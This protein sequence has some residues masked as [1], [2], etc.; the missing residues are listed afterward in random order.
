MIVQV[1]GALLRRLFAAAALMLAAAHAQAQN[2]EAG[3]DVWLNKC[4]SCHAPED[5]E[6]RSAGQINTA[7]ASVG[8]MNGISLSGT[9]M[10]NLVSY[11]SSAHIHHPRVT[12]LP[13]APGPIN[14]PSVSSGLTRTQNVTVT[15]TGLGDPLNI[16]VGV[17]DNTN[18]SVN[19]NGCGT[20]AQNASCNI[21]VTFRP[22]SVGVFNGRTLTINHNT[23][24]T[25]SAIT[26]NGTGLVEFSASPLTLTYTSPT[27]LQQT[28]IT[29]NKGDALRICRAD[30]A[31]FNFPEDFALDAPNTLGVDGCFTTTATGLVPRSIPLNVR[32]TPGATGPRNGAL[33]IRRFVGGVGVGNTSTVQL[34]GNP[35]PV[36]AVN[37]SSLFD[38]PADPG[39]EVDNGNF[40]DRS[41]TLFS[42]GS[43]ALAF[44]GSTFAISGANSADYSVVPG[45]CQALAGL[46]ASTGGVPPSCVL[47]VRFN[48]SAVGLRS[49]TLTVQIAGVP[50]NVI[51]LNG[52]GFLGPRLSVRRNGIPATGGDAVQFGTQTIGGLYPAIPFTL[53]NG[54]TLGDLEVVLPAAGSLTGFAFAAGAG[55]ANLAPAASCTLDL[56][57]D[58]AAVQ[59][60]ATPFTI[61]TRPAGSAAAYDDFVLNLAGTGSAAAMPV[62]S[63]TDTSG[64]PIT[65]LDFADTDAGSP[66]TGLVRLYNAGPGGVNLQVANVVGLDAS[67][68]VLDT[69]ACAGGSIVYELTSCELPVQF[70][71]GTAGLKTASIQL[72]ANAGTPP[73]LVVAP[74]LTASGT[75]ISSLPPATLAVSATNLAFGSAIVGSAG[76]PLELRLTNTGTRNL[77][78]SGLTASAP[79]TVQAKSCASLPFVLVPGGECTLT[80]GFQPQGEGDLTGTL[81]ITSDAT[82]AALEVALSGHGAE[83]PDVSGGGC[84]IASGTSATDPTLWALVLLAAL[85][86][87]RRQAR[88]RAER[89]ERHRA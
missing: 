86:L 20:I 26:L 13:A 1:R 52:T 27:V 81:T 49:A 60:F 87:L 63:W 57:F 51:A 44:T 54:G 40:I 65:R 67:N 37:A 73:S 76:Q 53:H 10:T 71:P 45:G 69:T 41:F 23:F 21:I 29:D 78:V 50:D 48:P 8:D 77:N 70:A 72:T 36:A 11:L 83:K 80:V 66:R 3:R 22:Q 7:I 16:S 75:A 18:Y 39:V 5:R 74:L 17:S 68:F 25:S 28:T 9:E 33:T 88:R 55:C 82:V 46:A 43:V 56:R 32:F 35:G 62:L 61:R 31:T 34:V 84:S 15:N 19:L 42:Q 12:L 85:V 24:V 79:F 58:P 2:W 47:T 6:N 14:F 4:D 89:A 38:A 64:T 59:A 30:A